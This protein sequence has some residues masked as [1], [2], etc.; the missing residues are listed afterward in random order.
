MGLLYVGQSLVVVQVPSHGV[1]T[2]LLY[3]SHQRLQNL[4]HESCLGTA[5]NIEPHQFTDSK[6]ASCVMLNIFTFSHV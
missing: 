1:A 3:I 2:C 4:F 5:G 6:R